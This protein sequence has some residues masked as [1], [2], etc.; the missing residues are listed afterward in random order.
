MPE[1]NRAKKTSLNKD[2]EERTTDAQSIASFFDR[3]ADR[4]FGHD[5]PDARNWR[6]EPITPRLV[7][8]LLRAIKAYPNSELE[9]DW[10][11]A[12]M[13]TEN[14]SP[15]KDVNKKPLPFTSDP[16]PQA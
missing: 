13:N 6:M 8:R 7:G 4:E 14:T 5:G 1:F 15:C 16:L 11:D 2:V 9:I 12:H 10:I 3:H